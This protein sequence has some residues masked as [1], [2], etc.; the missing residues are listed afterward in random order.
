MQNKNSDN[1]I[2]KHP[3]FLEFKSIN[4]FFSAFSYPEAVHFLTTSFIAAESPFFWN[5]REPADLLSFFCEFKELIIGSF[6]IQYDNNSLN[7]YTATPDFNDP[8]FVSLFCSGIDTDNAW[9]FFP[10]Y[11]SAS[12]FNNPLFAIKQFTNFYSL[13]IWKEKI[14]SFLKFA[15]SKHSIVD[16]DLTSMPFQESYLLFKLIEA[17]HLIHVRSKT[18]NVSYF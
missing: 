6:S 8:N 13:K 16:L 10:R 5:N 9:L 15:L 3:K 18:L 11:L 7:D 12:E 17:S 4:S 2:F 14:D 1:L